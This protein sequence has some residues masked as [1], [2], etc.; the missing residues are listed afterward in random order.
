[1]FYANKDINLALMQ[2][3]S[4]HIG[5]GLPHSEQFYSP[6]CHKEYYQKSRDQHY[7]DYSEDHYNML[8]RKKNKAS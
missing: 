8:K 4:T 5:L 7:I 1:M 2:V 3:A 6:G